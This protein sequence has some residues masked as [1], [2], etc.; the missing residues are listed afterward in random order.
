MR[1]AI[2]GDWHGDLDWAEVCCQQANEL[3]IEYVLQVGDFGMVFDRYKVPDL[4]KIAAQYNVHIAFLP[5][6]HEDHDELELYYDTVDEIGPCNGKLLT[7]H[8]EYLGRVNRFELGGIHIT[9]I[10]GAVSVDQ[11]HRSPHISWWPQEVTTDDDVTLASALGES[12]LL[13]SH[14][15]PINSHLEA[16]L[17]DWDVDGSFWPERLTIASRANRERISAT[18]AAVRPKLVVHG[19]YH[20]AYECDMGSYH[21]VGLNRNNNN[22]GSIRFIE[23]ESF[24]R[25]E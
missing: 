4:E 5:G 20:F 7:P 15:A 2:C 22:R 25:H 6:N 11:D 17:D 24:I 8:V 12:E 21:V 1:L 9:T 14:D 10:G 23:T 3:G 13:L 16:I 19:H 18:V